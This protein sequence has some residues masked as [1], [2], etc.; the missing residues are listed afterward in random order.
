LKDHGNGPDVPVAFSAL[1]ARAR[2]ERGIGVS[3]FSA[4]AE[5]LTKFRS[6]LEEIAGARAASDAAHAAASAEP[7][8]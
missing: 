6:E 7:P 8:A 3:D 4:L 2:H 5:R 1:N